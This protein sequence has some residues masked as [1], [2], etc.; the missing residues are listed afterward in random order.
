MYYLIY[1]LFF[2]NTM[3]WFSCGHSFGLTSPHELAVVISGVSIGEKLSSNWFLLRCWQPWNLMNWYFFPVCLFFSTV[4]LLLSLF[5]ELL[6]FW[7]KT[8]YKNA[9]KKK[10]EWKVRM[11]WMKG[12]TE[13]NI[14]M[15]QPRYI[16]PPLVLL[17]LT[18]ALCQCSLCVS[19]QFWERNSA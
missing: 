12:G 2:Y 11:Q 13:A 14:F 9:N 5:I 1:F 19:T 16:V 15:E 17:T 4:T 8:F 7:V 18:T 6:M 10:W 3:W